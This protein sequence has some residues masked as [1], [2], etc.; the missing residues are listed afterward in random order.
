MNSQERGQYEQNQSKSEESINTKDFLIGALIG[1]MVGAAAALFLAPKSGKELRSNINE[2]AIVLKGKS[3][4]FR[5][6]AKAKGTQLAVVAKEKSN[7]IA[8]T[9]SKQSTDIVNKVKS[10]TPTVKTIGKVENSDT[11]K[12]EQAKSDD[13]QKKL[14]ETKKAFDETEYKYNQ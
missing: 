8:Q 14:E 4:Q 12:S 2:Q 1:G 11:D 10:M 6:T 13:I 9:V 3:G 7:V 5:D